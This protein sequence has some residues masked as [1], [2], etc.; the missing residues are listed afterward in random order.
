MPILVPPFVLPP[1]VF[2]VK[3]LAVVAYFAT[4][5]NLNSNEVEI[6]NVINDGYNAFYNDLYYYELSLLK[7][8]ANRPVE[9]TESDAFPEVTLPSGTIV[10]GREYSK[11]R[12][13]HNIQFAEA[14]VGDLRYC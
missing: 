4:F 12:T 8:P 6:V 10:K 11:T 9:E 1:F 14:P 13:F 7:D 5:S 3:L 2:T